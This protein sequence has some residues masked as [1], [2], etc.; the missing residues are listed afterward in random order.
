MQG[1]G[2]GNTSS[3]GG[4]QLGS[5][6]QSQPKDSDSKTAEDKTTSSSVSKEKTDT[7]KFNPVFG[8]GK[9][10]NNFSLGAAPSLAAGGVSSLTSGGFQF[11]ASPANKDV[12]SGFGSGLGST[13]TSDAAKPDSGKPGVAVPSVPSGFSFGAVSK[14]DSDALPKPGL[15]AA[16]STSENGPTKS[17]QSTTSSQGFTFGVPEAATT[18]AATNLFNSV[19]QLSS[20]GF[21]ANPGPNPATK[22]PVNGEVGSGLFSFS[23]QPATGS[24]ATG[25]FVF[26]ASGV[27]TKD[28]AGATNSLT[29]SKPFSFGA[30]ATASHSTSEKC[31]LDNGE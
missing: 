16:D 19:P 24:S 8:T 5:F 15:F 23:Q 3:T 4:F 20:G 2:L 10:G 25:G 9:P 26:G 30:E 6:T 12:S 1:F 22:L 31:H 7:P 13:V 11:P 14:P 17:A 18:T 29:Q 28:T 21:G 27:N